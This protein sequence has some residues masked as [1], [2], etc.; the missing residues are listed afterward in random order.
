[1]SE[2]LYNENLDLIYFTV[3]LRA[4]LL[5]QHRFAEPCKMS[6]WVPFGLYSVAIIH[7]GTYDATGVMP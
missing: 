4:F 1:M 6:S 5:S 7:M 3:H 2:V